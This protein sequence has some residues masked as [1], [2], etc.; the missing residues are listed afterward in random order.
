MF[1]LQSFVK[2]RVNAGELDLHCVGGHCGSAIRFGQ[3]LLGFLITTPPS[4][5]VPAVLGALAVW[6]ENQKKK[7]LG[8]QTHFRAK[9][10][11]EGPYNW[12]Q[13]RGKWR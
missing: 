6:I 7:Q 1:S 11:S 8:P 12:S 13:N 3:A 4:V 2:C 9:S 10:Q 5:C